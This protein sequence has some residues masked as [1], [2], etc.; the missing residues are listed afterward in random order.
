M[1]KKLLHGFFFSLAFNKICRC[2]CGEGWLVGVFFGFVSF[3]AVFCLAS[4]SL[5]LFLK[6]LELLFVQAAFDIIKNVDKF[7]ERFFFFLS[8]FFPPYKNER[9]FVLPDLLKSH[10]SS[11]GGQMYCFE[12][13]E[14]CSNFITMYCPSWEWR[15]VETLLGS[16][17][18]FPC[19][20]CRPASVWLLS[21]SA[22]GLNQLAKASGA[23]KLTGEI[24][25]CE[26]NCWIVFLWKS[27]QQWRNLLP[28]HCIQCIINYWPNTPCKI[29]FSMSIGT[30]ELIAIRNRSVHTLPSS[31]KVPFV[32]INLNVDYWQVGASNWNDLK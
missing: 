32:S 17:E 15:C 12:V 7:Q 9:L 31:A 27:M 5:L 1:V 16:A 11:L 25:L 24:T 8:F 21:R 18:H 19:G 3:I 14:T 4:F 20:C 10:F 28:H 2:V 22:L 23:E 26:Q 6:L 30:M 13:Y 29:Q